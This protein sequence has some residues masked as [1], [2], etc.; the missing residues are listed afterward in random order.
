MHKK[1]RFPSLPSA[2]SL[3][4]AL[5]LFPEEIRAVGRHPFGDDRRRIERGEERKQEDG[6]AQVSVAPRQQDRRHLL[7]Q[8]AT[9]A[10]LNTR[11]N[12]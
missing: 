1:L 10:L 4:I 6:I 3:S 11:I 7:I 12:T 2:L 5:F 9:F 8:I